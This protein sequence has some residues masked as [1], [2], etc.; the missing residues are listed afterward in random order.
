[1]KTLL[2][3]FATLFFLGCSAPNNL[4][5]TFTGVVQQDALHNIKIIIFPEVTGQTVPYGISVIQRPNLPDMYV[6]YMKVDSI[7]GAH[8]EN[9]D[10]LPII[11]LAEMSNS[12]GIKLSLAFLEKNQNR[13]PQITVF[14][15]KNSAVIV[16]P[17]YYIKGV[18]QYMHQ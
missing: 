5:K 6:V 12:M 14:G 17:D 2:V 9:G 8:A 4:P 10:K 7:E 11:P 3:F 18:L 13:N 16:L 1:M 15:A